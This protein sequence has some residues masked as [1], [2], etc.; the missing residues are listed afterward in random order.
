MTS[1][2][3][4][5]VDKAKKSSLFRT[6]SAPRRTHA[7]HFPLMAVQRDSTW[8]DDDVPNSPALPDA[9]EEAGFRDSKRL[10]M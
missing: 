5:D 6:R 2:E 4:E 9:N 3:S 7:F 8:E 10:T 1:G